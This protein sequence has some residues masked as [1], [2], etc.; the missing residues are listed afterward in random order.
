METIVVLSDALVSAKT[1]Y[2]TFDAQGHT[3]VVTTSEARIARPFAAYTTTDARGRVETV[4]GKLESARIEY[5]TTTQFTS[6]ITTTNVAGRPTSFSAVIVE[7]VVLST[8]PAPD[9]VNVSKT[10]SAVLPTATTPKPKFVLSSQE[11]IVNTKFTHESYFLALYLP[12]LLAVVAKAAWE[13]VFSAIKLIQPFERMA[14][15]LRALDIPSSHSTCPARY[16]GMRSTRCL[17]V[18]PCHQRV[19]SM[20]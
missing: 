6:L 2:T 10:S 17:R 7:T 5:T 14:M 12:A 11:K 3:H 9:N 4:V 13:T 8:N 19:F 16:P 15:L 18:I 20:S 1:T